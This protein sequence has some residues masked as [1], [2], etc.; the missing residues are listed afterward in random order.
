MREKVNSRHDKRKQ[1]GPAI[2]ASSSPKKVSSL[3][4]DFFGLN[5]KCLIPH[6]G[7]CNAMSD[8]YV[9]FT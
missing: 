8:L 9:I 2:E 7:A 1:E 3:S 6:D 5:F 4:L